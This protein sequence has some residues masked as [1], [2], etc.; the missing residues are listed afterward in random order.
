[1]YRIDYIN[2]II[3]EYHYKTILCI[4]VGYGKWFRY[5]RCP[6]IFVVDIYSTIPWIYRKETIVKRII[7]KFFGRF[8]DVFQGSVHDFYEHYKEKL[9]KYTPDIIFIDGIHIQEEVSYEIQRAID[10]IS[11]DGIVLVH[12]T[13]PQNETQR[14]PY[15]N[16]YE[17]LENQP[18]DFDGVWC[19]EVYKAI[20]ELQ[21]NKKDVRFDVV[22][23]SNGITVIRKI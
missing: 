14:L 15:N 8:T 18:D 16:Y 3:K 17:M 11:K 5:I 2:N 21:K 23:I 22:A 7:R 9:Q 19:G 12:N 1:M 13:N 4:G 6:R 20:E 10:N